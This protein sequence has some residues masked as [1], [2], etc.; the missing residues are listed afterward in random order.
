VL[1]LFNIL[2]APV[3]DF[4]ADGVGL[5]LLRT[6]KARQSDFRGCKRHH[7]QLGIAAMGRNAELRSLGCGADA[8]LLQFLSSPPGD[9]GRVKNA[10]DSAR[11]FPASRAHR[12]KAAYLASIDGMT[13]GE[14]PVTFTAQQVLFKD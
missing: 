13:Y 14:D 9:A 4:D 8:R 7:A 6:Q 10:D 12:D 5:Q 3:R 11:Q 1:L 2:M